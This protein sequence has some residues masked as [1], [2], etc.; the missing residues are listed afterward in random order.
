MIDHVSLAVRDLAAAGRFYDG[1]LGVI[2]YSRLAARET[3]LGYGKRYPEL[4]LNARPL[5]TPPPTDSGMHVCLRVATVEAVR[6]FHAVAL[7]G[8]GACD[9][10]PGERQAA[11]TRYYAAFIRDADGNRIEAACFPRPPG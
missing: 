11:M 8:G 3:T 6:A 10:P 1:V 7:A 5:A 9:G 2:G 4:W